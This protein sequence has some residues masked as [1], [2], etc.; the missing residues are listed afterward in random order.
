MSNNEKHNVE[1]SSSS[2]STLQPTGN[3]GQVL[4]LPAGL[5]NKAKMKHLFDENMK[6]CNIIVFFVVIQFIC[7]VIIAIHSFTDPANP[8]GVQCVVVLSTILVTVVGVL[9]ISIWT[10]TAKLQSFIMT[11]ST[12][13]RNEIKK[14]TV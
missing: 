12:E 8:F 2:S 1:S 9:A 7:G 5:A 11:D 14:K 3:N 6:L 4:V 10:S 13:T